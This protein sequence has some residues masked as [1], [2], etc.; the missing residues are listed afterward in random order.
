M[1]AQSSNGLIYVANNAGLLEFNGAL[2]TLYPSPNESIIRSVLAVDDKVYTGCYMNFGV[3]ERNMVGTLEYTSLSDLLKISIIEDEQFWN[4]VSHQKWIVLQSFDRLLIL[5]EETREV[6]TIETENAIS[7]VFKLGDQIFFQVLNEGVYIIEN[8][9]KKIVANDDVAKFERMIGLFNLQST[10]TF[11][12]ESRG[13]FQLKEH[14]LLKWNVPINSFLENCTIYSAAQRTDESVVLGTIA[15]GLVSVSNTGEQQYQL[16]QINGLANNTV[17][18]VFEDRDKNVWL[19]LDNGIDCVNAEAPLRNYID[20]E[21]KLGSTYASIIYK[22]SSYLGT[23]QGLFYRPLD[24]IDYSIVPGT[25]GQVWYLKVFDDVL[26]CGHNEG[27]FTVDNGI[28]KQISTIQGGWDLKVAPNMPDLLVQGNY[29]GLYTL[30]KNNGVW[31]IRGRLE[32]FDISSRYFE[33][34]SD[35]RILVNHEYKGVYEL[36]VNSN[37]TKV[38]GYAKM[39]DVQRSA[40]SSLTSYNGAIFYANKYGIYRYSED[41]RMFVRHAQLSSIFNDGEYVSGKLVALNQELWAF[42]KSYVYHI[43]EESIDRSF[44]LNKISIPQILR[45]EIEGFE[46]ISM[47][48]EGLSMFGTSSGYLLMDPSKQNKTEYDVDITKVTST[49]IRDSIELLSLKEQP[50]LEW[51]ENDLDF[52]YSVPEYEKYLIT[53]YQYKINEVQEEWSPWSEENNVGL[54]NLDHGNYTFHV[55]AKVNNQVTRN[56]STFSFTIAKPWYLS[57][58]AIVGYFLLG[59][60]LF[61]GIHWFYKRYYRKQRERILEKTT[62]DLKL[63]EYASQKQIIELKNEGLLADIDA[64]NRELAISTMNMINKNKTLNSIKEE[65]IK[66]SDGTQVKSVIDNIDKSLNNKKDWEFFEEAFNYAD[67]DFFKKVKDRHPDL[68]SNDLRLC[69][70]LRLNL[71]SKEIAPLLNISPRSVEIKRYR[72]RKKINLSREKNLNEYFIEM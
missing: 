24:G 1:L 49:S 46:N 7:K 69:V 33:F 30:S 10:P 35:D 12:S 17:L 9:E 56:V 70:Y 39:N 14:R 55:R 25:E 29:T 43:S 61:L 41:D 4:I 8:G 19:G 54:N 47:Y 48:Q 44:R 65:L 2:W 62:N 32:G 42:T 58:A 72:L 68:T 18:S 3:W 22:N 21:G 28:A 13:F 15:N 67:K 6:R 37:F 63:K 20:K 71:S 31:E 40:H 50:L 53:K 5:N 36:N 16:N 66:L 51:N 52:Y 23:N 11:I 64:R 27:T 59:G 38:E 34:T 60:L 26:F 45:N 57:S